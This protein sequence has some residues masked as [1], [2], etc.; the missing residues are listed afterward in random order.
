[1]SSALG[2]KIGCNSVAW[3][4]DVEF[5]KRKHTNCQCRVTIQ[6]YS[7]SWGLG[8]VNV[9]YKT[10]PSVF[11]MAKSIKQNTQSRGLYEQD[12]S[13]SHSEA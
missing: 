10:L 9:C 2:G 4:A 1:M 13:G 12:I 8:L 5:K 6:T 11:E 3:I 7:R